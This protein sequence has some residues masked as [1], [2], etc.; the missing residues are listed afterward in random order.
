MS[1]STTPIGDLETAQQLR[2]EGVAAVLAAD[3]AVH[4]GDRDRIEAALAELCR[5]GEPFTADHVARLVLESDPTPYKGLV[6]ASTM[7]MWSRRGDIVPVWS[8][9]MV[10]STRRSRHAARLTWWRSAG[11]VVAGEVAA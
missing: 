8:R 1:Y 2:D 3:V 11:V 7:A 5:S 10:Q 6:L 9:P 4:R